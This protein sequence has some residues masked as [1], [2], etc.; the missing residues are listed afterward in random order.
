MSETYRHLFTSAP[1]PILSVDH[2]GLVV[3]CNPAVAGL[4]GRSAV[5]LVGTPV[6][7]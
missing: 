5:E 6:L 3:A 2:D 1:L 7:K 4:L